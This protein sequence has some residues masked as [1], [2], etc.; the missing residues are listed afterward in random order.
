MDGK[1]LRSD[2]GKL[3]CKSWRIFKL[4][5]LF[6]SG[7]MLRLF[8]RNLGFENV[9]LNLENLLNLWFIFLVNINWIIRIF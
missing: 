3:V 4:G 6:M 7:N 2:Y 8:G 1:C 9:C 5:F